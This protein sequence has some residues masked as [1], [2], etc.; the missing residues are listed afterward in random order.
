MEAW[1]NEA[2]DQSDPNIPVDLVGVISLFVD[3]LE[4]F[5]CGSDAHALEIVHRKECPE[6]LLNCRQSVS[7][8]YRRLEETLEGKKS[9]FYA[10][11][12]VVEFAE[13]GMMI[14]P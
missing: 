7:R 10:P 3:D 2:L 6:I 1:V 13:V 14:S 11:S 5:F 12:Q 4:L 9:G 8:E